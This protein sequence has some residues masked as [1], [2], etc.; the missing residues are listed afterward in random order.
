MINKF[1]KYECSNILLYYNNKSQ[2]Q[3][4]INNVNNTELNYKNLKVF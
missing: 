3:Y 4:F 1:L 2:A